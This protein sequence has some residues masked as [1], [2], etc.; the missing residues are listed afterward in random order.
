MLAGLQ[1]PCGFES[2]RGHHHYT[3]AMS[4]EKRKRGPDPERVKFEGDWEEAIRKAL[5]KER[6]PEGW[7]EPKKNEKRRGKRRSE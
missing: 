7:P 3:Q 5:R 6:P 4:D 1:G 2:H